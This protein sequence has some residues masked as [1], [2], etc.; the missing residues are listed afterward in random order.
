MVGFIVARDVPF[1]PRYHHSPCPVTIPVVMEWNLGRHY[2]G[3]K[4]QR[5]TFCETDVRGGETRIFE[6]AHSENCDV[7]LT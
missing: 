4:Q 6:I 3:L 1:R 2:F 5:A 7:S